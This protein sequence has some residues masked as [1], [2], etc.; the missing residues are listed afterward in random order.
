MN[1]DIS[2]TIS[3][4]E[5]KKCEYCRQDAGQPCVDLGPA[6]RI[7]HDSAKFV[8]RVRL[9]SYRADLAQSNTLG[10]TQ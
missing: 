8:H 3:A 9:D 5:T 1:K 4:A 7:Q 2:E 6:I 10:E